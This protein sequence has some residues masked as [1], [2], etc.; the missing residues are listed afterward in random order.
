MSQSDLAGDWQYLGLIT[1][2]FEQWQRFPVSTNSFSPLI[3]LTFYDESEFNR[4]GS[5]GF[6]RVAYNFPDTFYSRWQRIYPS[7]DRQ[8]LSFSIPNE[9]LLT[10]SVV[11]RHF[12]IM[13]RN[14]YSNPK[15]TVNDTF[16][17]C[18]IES[19]ELINLTNEDQVLLNQVETLEQVGTIIQEQITQGDP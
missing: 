12:E 6:L 10:S 3:R 1:P 5:Y 14:K 8:V 18:A 4:I 7:A 11:L 2:E 15:F 9:L 13:K 16:W 19:M 17:S